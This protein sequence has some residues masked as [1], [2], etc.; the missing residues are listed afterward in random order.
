VLE[1]GR[2]PDELA[3][4]QPIKRSAALARITRREKAADATPTRTDLEKL[5]YP[6]CIDQRRFGCRF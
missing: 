5:E 6:E 4:G 1:A 2:H 3:F